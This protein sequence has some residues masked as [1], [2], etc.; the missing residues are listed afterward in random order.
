MRLNRATTGIIVSILFSQLVGCAQS[1]KDLLAEAQYCLDKATSATAASCMSK[2]SG[3]SSPQ[4]HALR[5][6]QGF[7]TAGITSAQNLSDAVTSIKQGSGAT[8]M[9][10]ALSFPNPN[11]LDN[12]KATFNSCSSSG[13]GGLALI[14]AMAKSATVIADIGGE[15]IIDACSDPARTQECKD[16]LKNTMNNLNPNSS[17]A[18]EIAATVGSVYEST[19][20]GSTSSSNEMCNQ[21]N[22]AAKDAGVNP[23]TMSEDEKTKFAEFLL[24][25]WNT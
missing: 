14:G 13:Q 16:A 19:C 1:D 24:K 18:K 4:A 23:S 15:Q 9:L 20:G 12:A 22:S 2:I 10:A 7:I 5:C 25:N 8:G 3:L 21:I 11:A 6:A 17:S